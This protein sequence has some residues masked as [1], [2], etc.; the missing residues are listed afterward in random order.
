ML[1][2]W[3]DCFT[4]HLVLGSWGC[5]VITA[6]MCTLIRVI[7]YCIVLLFP[8]LVDMYAVVYANTIFLVYTSLRWQRGSILGANPVYRWRFFFLFFFSWESNIDH[9]GLNQFEFW[10]LSIVVVVPVGREVDC[11]RKVNVMD[12]L[13]VLFYYVTDCSLVVDDL[14]IV[15]KEMLYM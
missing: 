8:F 13:P 1:E 3:R 14:R 5:R 6:L 15:S 4:L 10:P 2:T 12:L 11:R 7:Y 9:E